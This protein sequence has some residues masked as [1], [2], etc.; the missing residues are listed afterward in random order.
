[1]FETLERLPTFKGPNKKAVVWTHNSLV[2]DARS[3]EE[4]RQVLIQPQLE[5]FIGAIYRPD[6][7]PWSHYSKAIL[8]KQFDAYVWIDETIALKPLHTKPIHHAVEMDE[9]SLSDSNQWYTQYRSKVI[10]RFSNG[11]MLILRPRLLN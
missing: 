11:L 1:M 5:Q 6:T 3:M 9:T 8:P 7:E 10:S 2:R 4:L